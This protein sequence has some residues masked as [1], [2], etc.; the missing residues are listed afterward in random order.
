MNRRV[1]EELLETHRSQRDYAKK[2]LDDHYYE[3]E[4][5]NQE[6]KWIN[7]YVK[8]KLFVEALEQEEPDD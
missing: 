5:R 4:E 8:H 1:L 7:R 6:T 2:M 3:L